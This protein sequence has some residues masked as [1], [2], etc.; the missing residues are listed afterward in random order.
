MI[1]SG[2]FC[3]RGIFSRKELSFLDGEPTGGELDVLEESSVLDW[4]N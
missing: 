1:M 4:G 3:F 2:W